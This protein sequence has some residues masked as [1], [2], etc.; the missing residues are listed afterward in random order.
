[1]RNASAFLELKLD[2]LVIVLKLFLCYT[3][4]L[5]ELLLLITELIWKYRT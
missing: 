4:A 3:L 5:E 1:M 2:I